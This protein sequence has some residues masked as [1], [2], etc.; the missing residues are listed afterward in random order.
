MLT[1]LALLRKYVL[2][3]RRNPAPVASDMFQ[4]PQKP[5]K[6]ADIPPPLVDL[7]FSDILGEDAELATELDPPVDLD[8]AHLEA[9]AAQLAE[10]EAIE[11]AKRP[12]FEGLTPEEA[13]VADELTQLPAH[14]NEDSDPKSMSDELER[15]E[16]RP[17]G[18]LERTP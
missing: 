17:G 18:S 16:M 4:Q 3:G 13:E 8:A 12:K 7:D 6:A 1:F 9:D 2:V 11:A 15:I 5:K 10:L 14:A